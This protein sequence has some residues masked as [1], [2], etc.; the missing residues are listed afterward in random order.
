MAAKS[1]KVK[2]I[3]TKVRF[4]FPHVF[5]PHASEEGDEPKYSVA[6]LIP[7]TDKELIAKINAA[8]EDCKKTNAAFFGGSVPKVLKGGLRDGDTERDTDRYPEYAGH[9]F[10]NANSYMKPD[11]VDAELN[12]ILDKN[13]FYS[14]CYGRVSLTFYP[15]SGKSSGIACGLGN[16]QKLE[17]GEKLGGASSAAADFAV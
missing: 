2:V 12:S 3:T 11:V 14:G 5:T 7:K 15:F 8:V 10:I 1:N 9:M 17:D 16:L 13:E 6:I 4:A